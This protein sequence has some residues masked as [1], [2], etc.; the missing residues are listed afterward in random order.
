[1]AVPTPP[2]SLKI[3]VIIDKTLGVIEH[4]IVPIALFIVGLTLVNGA[5]AW[6]ALGRTAAMDQAVIG[7]VNLG[8][9]LV[10]GYLLLNAVI[11]RLGLN[12]RGG[13]DVFFAYCGLALIVT[14]CFILGIIALVIPGLVIMARWGIAA[15]LLVARGDGIKQAL[16]ESWERTRGAEF[17]ILGAALA[18]LLLPIAV[19]IACAMLFEQGNLVGL[20]VSTLANSA[21]SVV[22]MAMGVAL[23]GLIV[24]TPARTFD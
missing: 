22:T 9:G 21:T 20:G 5:V 18:L 8:V 6:F 2:R 1:M 16:G 17:T 11:N 10:A 19:M 24:G 14:V 4:S 15:P 7:L 23:Y 12:E 3:G 13:K